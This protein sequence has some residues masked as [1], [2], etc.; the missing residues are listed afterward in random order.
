MCVDKITTQKLDSSCLRWAELLCNWQS[1]SPSV[2][3]SSPSATLDQ[4]LAEVRQL[5]EDGSVCLYLTHAWSLLHLNLWNLLCWTLDWSFQHMTLWI[6]LLSTLDCSLH[7]MTLWSLLCS[8]LYCS[9][10]VWVSLS[11]L[12]VSQSINQTVRLGLEP[13]L[14]CVCVSAVYVQAV[15][16]SVCCLSCVPSLPCVLCLSLLS[17]LVFTRHHLLH[18]VW[19]EGTQFPLA[20]QSDKILGCLKPLSRRLFQK[21]MLISSAISEICCPEYVYRP[22]P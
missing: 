20:T 1:V 14:V 7:H 12:Q 3:A 8:T 16:R 17:R 18:C 9:L 22:A 11:Y 15:S 13:C 5:R 2:L 6:L 19:S 10:L 4:I 21:L